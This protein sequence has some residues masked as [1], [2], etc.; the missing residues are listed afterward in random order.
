MKH[1]VNSHAATTGF[2]VRAYGRTELAVRYSPNLSKESAWRKLKKWIMTN[3]ELRQWLAP[4]GELVMGRS[5]TPRQV[6]LIV[7]QLGEP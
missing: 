5:F 4:G 1:E 3:P 6:K 2:A 7:E